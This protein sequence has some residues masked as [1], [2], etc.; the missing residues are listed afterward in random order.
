MMVLYV[1]SRSKSLCVSTSGWI[2]VNKWKNSF[3]VGWF[4]INDWWYMFNNLF[5][6]QYRFNYSGPSDNEDDKTLDPNMT[7][8]IDNKIDNNVMIK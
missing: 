6:D 4:V 8:N 2:S 3:I 1:S 7:V 5:V